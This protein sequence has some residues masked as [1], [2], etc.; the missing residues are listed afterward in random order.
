MTHAIVREPSRSFGRCL[1]SHPLSH[2]ISVEKAKNQHRQYCQIL[3]DL[4]IDLIQLDPDDRFPDSCFVEDTA[5]IHQNKALISRMGIQSR[6]GE[7]QS[8]LE[9]LTEYLSVKQTPSPATIEGGDVIHFSDFLIS[10]LSQRTNLKGIHSIQEWLEIDVKTVS[11]PEITHLKSYVTYLDHNTVIMNTRFVN[12]PIFLDFDKIVVIDHESYAANT[13]T[14]NGAVLVPKNH[15]TVVKQLKNH[16][17][18]VVTINM[19][20][21]E[22]CEGALTCL[23]LL[24]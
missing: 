8:I 21:F 17:Y 9:I 2:T 15:S 11:A 20:E 23:S 10:G 19:S 6:R 7:E 1:S 16:G 18:D 12:H 24:F 13:L 22:K 3:S 4:G 14:I 5:I